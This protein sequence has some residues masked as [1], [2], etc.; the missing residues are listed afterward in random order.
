[1]GIDSLICNEKYT[2]TYREIQELI[3]QFQ[4]TIELPRFIVKIFLIVE[5]RRLQQLGAI[6]GE[7][8]GHE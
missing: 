1:M 4:E 8:P 5:G 3:F 7:I 2:I 6:E